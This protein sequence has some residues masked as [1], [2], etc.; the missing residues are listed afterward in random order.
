MTTS[1]IKKEFMKTYKSDNDDI[2][3]F[4]YGGD[5]YDFD[6]E[7]AWSFIETSINQAIQEEDKKIYKKLDNLLDK[8]RAKELADNF[9]IFSGIRYCKICGYNPE[10]QRKMILDLLTH[11]DLKG[12]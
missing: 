4:P 1:K 2:S 10:K 6:E 8:K 12:K 3:W 11:T 9:D 5:D 7:N